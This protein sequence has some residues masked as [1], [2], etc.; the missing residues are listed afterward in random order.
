MT[1]NRMARSAPKSPYLCASVAAIFALA[2]LGCGPASV[3]NDEGKGSSG[4]TGATS[5]TGSS[6]AGGT[7]IDLTKTTATGGSTASTRGCSSTSTTGCKA[8]APE[9]CGDGINNQA[10]TED[11]DDGN[12][13]PG[14][15]CNGICKVEINWDCPPA[16]PC[17]RKIICGDGVIG[18][19]EVCD[20][21]NATD[22][23]G[24]NATCTVQD[25]AFHCVAG[26]PCT[27]ISQCG[28]SRIEAGETCDDGN[29]TSGD[30]CSS[31]CQLES[32]WVCGKPG[33]PCKKAPACGDG[34]VNL[35]RGEV[36]D[37]G[38]TKDNDGCSADCKTKGPGCVCTP[39]S[40]CKCAAVICGNGAIEGGEACDDGNTR[41]GDGC[42]G[43]CTIESGYACPFSN[44]PCVPDCGDGIVLSPMEECDPGAKGTGMAQACSATCKWNEG[45]A[46]TGTPPNCHQTTCGDGKVEGKEG[47]DDGNTGDGDGCSATCTVEA[48]YQCEQP[49]NTAATMT[50][51]VVYRDFLFGGDFEPAATGKNAAVVGLVKNTLDT[52]GKPV[53]S[54][55]LGQPGYLTTADSFSHWYRDVPGTNTTYKSTLTLHN[56]GRG[57]YVNWLLNDKQWSGFGN[58][59]WCPDADTT[60]ASCNP[61]DAAIVPGNVTG[62]RTG[63]TCTC[64]HPCTPWGI[65]NANTCIGEIVT[66]EGNPVF[67]PVD[68]VP[69]MITP[70]TQY[71]SAT[72]P[73]AYGGGFGDEPG[74]PLHNFSFT[75]EVRYWF[76]YVSSKQ[77]TLDFTGDDDVWVFVNRTLAVD[78]GGIHTPVN[79]RLVL[80]ATGGGTVTTTQTE[81]GT[82]VAGVTTYPSTTKTVVLGM[83]SGGV[84]EIAVFQAERQ[85]TSSTYKLTL[86]GFNDSASQCKPICGDGVVAPGEQCDNGTAKNLGG[87]NQCTSGCLLGPYC[88]DGK[89]DADHEACDNGVNDTE[90]GAASG[91]APGCKAP[92]RCGDGVVQPEWDEECD[93]GPANLTSTDA[94]AAYGGK[95]LANC[96]AGASCG[97]GKVNGPETCDDGANDG[98]Y[99]T[100]NPDCTPAPKCGDGVVQSEYG[101]ECEPSMSDDP[102]CTNLCRKPGVCGDGRIQPPELCDDGAANNKGDYG[103][104]A[105]SCIFAPHCGDGIPN[106][107]EECDD[108]VRDGSYG[109]CTQQCKLG[110]HCG[111]GHQDGQEECDDGALNG[112][113]GTCTTSC[114]KVI[115]VSY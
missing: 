115:F 78:L 40:P 87:Y 80:N 94:N 111:D 79:G 54:G 18:P 29:S 84:Y 3:V 70:I 21:G 14:D 48:G 49:P 89:V 25:P 11:C 81:G 96:K 7:P 60:C 74:K 27:R 98:T 37:D 5:G 26:Q 35:S 110:P 10:G 104:C 82:T 65:G 2:A 107:P 64:M 55:V 34:V 93:D 19:G 32:G 28:N 4:A 75:S 58:V 33:T 51:P 99:G 91:C 44:A 15:G 66:Y 113:T 41:D 85:T 39:G 106:G 20:D 108:G 23:D 114:K 102:A 38:N 6:G 12:T 31:G 8:K 105:P 97:D 86:S 13:V 67:Y 50:A 62:C 42:S 1:K 112:P 56:N 109:G 63:M 17:K 100:C 46:C 73:T 24:C 57:G 9:G 43:K 59:R 47:C 52:D 36:C 77:Y 22:N 69:G 101:E 71:R 53:S 61:Y 103:G 45:W 76:G 88:G 92:A 68:N 72:I 16:G 83:T 95:C 90:Y 30:G